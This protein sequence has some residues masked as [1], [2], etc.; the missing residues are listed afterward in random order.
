MNNTLNSKKT[1]A[2][3][4]ITN[5][6]N[7]LYSINSTPNLSVY[8]ITSSSTLPYVYGFTSLGTISLSDVPIDLSFDLINMKAYVP[9]AND[10]ISIVNL[11]TRSVINEIINQKYI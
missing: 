1:K 9:M 8:Q 2:Y 4:I 6:T 7:Y 3:S 11:S 5:N 10:K